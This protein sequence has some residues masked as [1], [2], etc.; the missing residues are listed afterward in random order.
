MLGA[1]IIGVCFVCFGVLG[2]IGALLLKLKI[3]AGGGAIWGES[4]IGILLLGLGGTAMGLINLFRNVLSDGILFA[5]SLLSLL[6][7]VGFVVESRARK[8][9]KEHNSGKHG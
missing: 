6:L 3:V 2:L 1:I 8:A 4:A 5:L 9:R 7:I